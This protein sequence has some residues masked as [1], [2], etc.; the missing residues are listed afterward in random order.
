MY[1][2]AVV[3]GLA[4]TSG[5]PLPFMIDT[6]LARLDEEH[7]N[8]VVEQF[9]PNASHQTIILSTDSEVNFEYYQKLEPYI[10]RS[11]TIQY[12]SDKGCTKKHDTYFF[13]KKGERIIEV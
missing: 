1:A 8:S 7:R 3:W 13:D 9:Y 11:F 4:L 6:P 10:S 2:T 5:R 12:D